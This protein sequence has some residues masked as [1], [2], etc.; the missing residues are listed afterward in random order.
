MIHLAALSNDPFFF[1]QKLAKQ[2]T[3]FVYSSSQ[4]MWDFRYG[5]DLKRTKAKKMRLPLM[6]GPEGECAL[7]DLHN[8]DFTVVC[9]RPST[10]KVSL[11]Y[12]VILSST[13]LWPAPTP[14]VKLRSRDGSRGAQ[15]FM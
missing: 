11:G 10:D 12:A 9:F 13:I 5:R 15:W 4:S 6:L 1:N 14:L 7:K 8:D 3:T 2:I